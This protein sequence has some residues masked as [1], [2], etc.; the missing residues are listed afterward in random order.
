[1]NRKLFLLFA[2]LRKYRFS[3]LLCNEFEWNVFEI[4]VHVQGI[5]YFRV[6]IGRTHVKTVAEARKGE[7][8]KFLKQIVDLANEVS[9]CDLVYTFFHPMLRDEQDIDKTN[10]QKLKG[11][12]VNC[13]VQNRKDKS[14][15][16]V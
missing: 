13:N 8:E 11:I 1:M 5:L 7:V 3:L 9:E 2:C 14:R 4:V 12:L 10:L 6:L 16:K 15:I